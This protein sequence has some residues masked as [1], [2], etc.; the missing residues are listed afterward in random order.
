MRENMNNLEYIAVAWFAIWCCSELIISLTSVI[1]K[2][3]VSSTKTDKYSFLIV[4]LSTFPP[5]LFAFLTNRHSIFS[6]GFGNFSA[7]FQ[8]MIYLGFLFIAFGVIIRLAAV[9]ALKQHFT[10]KVS[11]VEGHKIVATGI[12]KTIRHPAYLG[13]WATML[14]I[15]LILGNWVG[16]AAL[17]VLPLLG[18][19]YRIRVEES[20]LLNYFGPAYQEYTN[21]TK[22]LLPK[23]W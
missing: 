22:R 17:V 6:N 18:I 4:W 19:L 3:A 8:F 12:Y 20:V 9:A 23:I 11:I 16:L 7:Q 15:G 2:P 1:N 13:H 5:I 21:R 10:V 14:G